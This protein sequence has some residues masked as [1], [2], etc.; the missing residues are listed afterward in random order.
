MKIDEKDTAYTYQTV[1][2]EGPGW[3]SADPTFDMMEHMAGVVISGECRD[4]NLQ[5]TRW[6]WLHQIVRHSFVVCNCGS[7]SGY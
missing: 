4:Y 3:F 5:A 7:T 6:G 1:G 2:T